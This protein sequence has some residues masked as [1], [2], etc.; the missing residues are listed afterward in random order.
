[1]GDPWIRL[2]PEPYTYFRVLDWFMPDVVKQALYKGA[3]A[4]SALSNPTRGL[5]TARRFK[6]LGALLSKIRINAGDQH[7]GSTLVLRTV[8]ENIC[9]SRNLTSDQK[10]CA[11]SC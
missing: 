11:L 2:D 7:P 1:M 4:I 9:L 10:S 8:Q 3:R 6:H 5:E